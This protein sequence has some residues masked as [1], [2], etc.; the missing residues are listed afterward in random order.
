LQGATGAQ[1]LQ[2]ETGL[3]GDIG[4]TGATGADGI[5]GPIGL[6]GATGEIGPIGPK[7]DTGDTG[8]AGAGVA[9]GGTAG[10][11]L[12]KVDA[13]DFNTA[14]IAA[15]S[16][17][18]SEVFPFING[19]A[20]GSFS[21]GAG[22]RAAESGSAYAP[23]ASML[24]NNAY[25]TLF[26]VPTTK[27]FDKMVFN[28]WSGASGGSV[29]AGI[30]TVGA[31]GL[32]DTAVRR[33]ALVVGTAGSKALAIQQVSLTGGTWYYL[34]LNNR[35]GTNLS[36]NGITE[37]AFAVFGDFQGMNANTHYGCIFFASTVALPATWTATSYTLQQAYPA[38]GVVAV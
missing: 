10:Q 15:P 9:S 2:G 4:L 33:T 11:L 8:P 22:G 17:G 19:R 5:Q 29:D 6:T 27:L 7:G 37:P 26:Y 1:G 20:Y 38:I 32:P 23:R 13:T 16:G 36:V 3:Q 35:S 14:W 12:S 30:Y 25:F 28:I 21:H 24:N 31:N 18:A 34:V